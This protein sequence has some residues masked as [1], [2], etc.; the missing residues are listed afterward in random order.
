MAT[1]LVLAGTTLPW[2]SDYQRDREIRGVDTEMADGSIVT[3]LVQASAKRI[4]RISWTSLTATQVATLEN[5]FDAI[6]DSSGSF[7]DMDGAS[8]T[9]TRGADAG[10]PVTSDTGKLQTNGPRYDVGP[11]VLREV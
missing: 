9:V 10:L 2:H 3:E 6:L 5:A 1:Q 8:Y 11:L 4:W 7:T